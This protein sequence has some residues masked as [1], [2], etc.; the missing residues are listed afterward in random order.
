MVYFKKKVYCKIGNYNYTFYFMFSRLKNFPRYC[1][2]R[3]KIYFSSLFFAYP[4]LQEGGAK[5]GLFPKKKKYLFYFRF[6][7][8]EPVL[9]KK[10][11]FYGA[12]TPIYL[13]FTPNDKSSPPIATD[14]GSVLQNILL[15]FQP[16]HR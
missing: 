1:H 12:K 10:S 7:R 2:D 3:Y 9:Y 4:A 13:L 6:H 5:H 15:F 16:A 11:L 14:V 8:Y